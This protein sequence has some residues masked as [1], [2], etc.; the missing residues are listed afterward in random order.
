MSETIDVND[1]IEPEHAKET[2]A[3]EPAADAYGARMAPVAIPQ[4]RSR[5]ALKTDYLLDG[6]HGPASPVGMHGWVG[7][8]EENDWWQQQAFLDP[9]D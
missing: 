9:V 4:P 2:G 5:E 3:D 7:N 1:D 6:A 8:D